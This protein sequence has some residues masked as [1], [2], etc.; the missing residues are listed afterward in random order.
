MSFQITNKK[1]DL[2]SAITENLEWVLRTEQMISLKKEIKD[3][4]GIEQ[5]QTQKQNLLKDLK[6]LYREL[7]IEIEFKSVV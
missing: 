4:F 1:E 5:Y 2:I 6:E 7:D 3:K